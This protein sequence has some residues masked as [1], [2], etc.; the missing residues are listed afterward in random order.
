MNGQQ[1]ILSA[2]VLAFS[3]FAASAS[4]L[5]PKGLGYDP[6]VPFDQLPKGELCPPSAGLSV[7]PEGHLLWNGKP[8]YFTATIWYGA[9]EFE[10]REDT[11]GYVDELK[12]LYQK[13]PDYAAMQRLGLDAGGVEAPLDWALKYVPWGR[14][15]RRDD[16]LLAPCITNGL[17]I[18]VDYTASEWSHGWFGRPQFNA[19]DPDDPGNPE[20]GHVTG[21]KGRLPQAAFAPA[22]HHF[23]PYSILNEKGRRIWLNMWVEGAKELMTR[24]PVKPWC[25]ELFNEPA[26][27]EERLVD[28]SLRPVD[29]I[30]VIEER[31]ASLLAEGQSALRQLDPEARA[32]FQPTTMRTRGI[33][34]YQANAPLAV[35]C[36]PTGGHGGA[37]EAHLLR[38][39][40]DGKPIVDSEMYVGGS[41]NSIRQSFMDQYQR[42]YSVSYMF[43]WSRRPCDWRVVHQVEETEG[44][45]KGVK[46]WR[47]WPEESLKKVGKVSAYNFMCPYKVATDQ[48]LGI[49]L[50]KR[51]IQDV[52]EFF[53]PRDRGVKRE[54]AVLFSSPTERLAQVSGGGNIRLFDAIVSGIDYAHLNPDVIFEPQLTNTLTW[55][56]RYKVL[57]MAGVTA[58]YPG[59]WKQILKW[60]EAGGR[61]LVFTDRADRDEYGG[62]NPDAP[63]LQE[64]TKMIGRGSI[65]YRAE[66]CGAAQMAADVARIGALSGVTPCCTALDALSEVGA[67]AASLEITPARR[68]SLDAYLI[69]SRAPTTQIVKFRPA[70]IAGA[71]RPLLVRLW[72]A[73]GADP[74]P[75]ADPQVRNLVSY[76]QPLKADK[77][78]F[79]VLTLDNATQ[80]YVY[81]DADEILKRYPRTPEVVWERGQTTEQALAAG[82]ARLAREKAER[83]V[84]QPLFD[85]DPNRLVFVRLHDFANVQNPGYNIPWGETD[86]R[87]IRF[88]FIRYDQN[89]FKDV[90]RLDKPVK[91]IPLESRAAALYFLHTAAPVYRVTYADGTQT[92]IAAKA[93]RE[94]MGWKDAEGHVLKLMRWE[95]PKPELALAKL[96]I[97]AARGGPQIVVAVTLEKPAPKTVKVEKLICKGGGR[98]VHANVDSNGVWNVMLDETAGSWV[99]A[100]LDVVPSIPCEPGRFTRLYFEMNRL[101]DAYG[102]YHDH[103]TPQL[104]I[105]GRTAEGKLVFGNWRVPMH[106]HGGW[107]YRTDNDPETWETCWIGT[108]KNFQ[109]D[110]FRKIISIALQFQMMP[111]EH[112]GLA[113]RN[114]RFEEAE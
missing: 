69:T 84:R 98:G 102:D 25:Y 56:N 16:A 66:K 13:M 35:V 86:C 57:A 91:G 39:L 68:G 110:Y 50:A 67:P 77:D 23:M 3:A 58:T 112:S 113:F 31:F 4:A 83:L 104:K 88:D 47:M 51:D 63:E 97:A 9:T 42:G 1:M 101:P 73:P 99:T 59:T 61:L 40:A 55:L 62:R 80:S 52:E 44:K 20:D 95:N 93:C 37:V 109:P 54:V 48:L 43:K 46:F 30:K 78:G 18:Y 36:A 103:A 82:K 81:G 6:F 28:P 38:A 14:K 45:W 85:V 96:D 24:F 7:A 106:K 29:R 22:G 8:R 15:P 90:I 89:K 33:D 64:G 107:A 65:T 72:T 87:G 53:T 41:T 76:R 108:D 17:P 71:R 26:C 32:C 79:Y 12:W 49:R 34:L 5:D 105:N 2:G 92:T 70:G 114:F 75:G 11:P 94:E 100:S 27:S 10:C 111:A 74:V 21:E 60:V 19:L